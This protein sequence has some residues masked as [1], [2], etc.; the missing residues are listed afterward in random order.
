MLVGCDG[1]GVSGERT[2]CGE[3]IASE[4]CE[5]EDGGVHCCG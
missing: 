5:G 1:D 4:S 3:G 2:W